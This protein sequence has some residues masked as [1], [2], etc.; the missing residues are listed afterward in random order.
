MRKAALQMS[1]KGPLHTLAQLREDTDGG[2]G[3]NDSDRWIHGGL[4]D[5]GGMP[6]T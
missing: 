5:E 6:E 1:G 2:W 3:A 4:R